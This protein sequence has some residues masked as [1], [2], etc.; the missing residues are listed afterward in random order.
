MGT[1]G[2]LDAGKA[3]AKR[4]LESGDELCG[5]E[6]AGDLGFGELVH[7]K[8]Y[9]KLRVGVQCD[10][11]SSSTTMDTK[12]HQGSKDIKTQRTLRKFGERG[13]LVPLTYAQR[14]YVRNAT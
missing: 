6:K 1:G 10:L 3:I 12:V 13:K 9:S 8:E 2:E 11:R 4:D 7:G 5:I 14:H